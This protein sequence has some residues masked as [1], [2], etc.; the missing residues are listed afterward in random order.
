MK[1]CILSDSHD[2]LKLLDMAFADANSRGA[3]AVLHCGDLVAPSTLKVARP[4]GLPVHVI[5]GNNTGDLFSLNRMAA[6]SGGQVHYYG[7]DA[8]IALGG[9]KIFIVHYPHYAEAM[10]TTGEWDIVCCGHDHRTRVE[11][12]DNIRGAKTV[13]VNPGTVGGIGAPATYIMADLE[14]MTFE[15]I[16]ISS[17]IQGYKLA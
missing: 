15:I 12:I 2:N 6:K 10:A 8:G 1:I 11:W 7:Q 3:E 9:K 14:A 13:L 4:Y 16:E 5:H 17:E